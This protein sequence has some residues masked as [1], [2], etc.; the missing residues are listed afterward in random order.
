MSKTKRGHAAG[1]EE[2][3]RVT[4]YLASIQEAAQWKKKGWKKYEE[5]GWIPKSIW[6][7]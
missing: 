1:M 2:D 3:S 5:R 6:G 7:A 4:A